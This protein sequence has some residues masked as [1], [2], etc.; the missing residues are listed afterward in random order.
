MTGLEQTLFDF[1]EIGR[2]TIQV[3]EKATCNPVEAAAC[4]GV[5]E[6]QIRNWVEDGTLLAINAA[7]EPI[8]E[9]R[10]R[11]L[12]ERWRIVVRRP[13]DIPPKDGNTF[14][15]LEELIGKISNINAEDP[16]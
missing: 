10:K 8:A 4:T 15:T 11:T 3:P 14:L 5:S 12:R 6:R 2:N 1:A 9:K 7:R 13:P 16:A